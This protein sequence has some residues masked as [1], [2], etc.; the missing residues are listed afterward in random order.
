MSP[1]ARYWLV[2]ASGER[3]AISAAGVMIGRSTRCDVVL[4][5]LRASRRQALVVDGEGGPVVMSLGRAPTSV[6]GAAVESHRQLADGDQLEVPGLTAKVVAGLS[7]IVRMASWLVRT[8]GGAR[9]G[10]ARTPFAIGGSATADLRIPGWPDDAIRLE[11]SEELFALAMVD[12]ELDGN[13]LVGGDS[14]RIERAATIRCGDT[15]IHLT[16]ADGEGPARS[17]PELRLDDEPSAA[18]IEFLPRGGRLTVV[19]GKREI[20]VYL[21]E[22]RC[23]LI[24]MLLRPPPP[25]LAGDYIS[26][27]V[28]LPRLWP[29]RV[30][31]RVDLNTL[32]HRV[33]H[34]LTQAGLDGASLLRRAPGGNATRFVLASGAIVRLL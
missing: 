3:F 28:V 34:D 32:L 12:V 9:F 13:L 19:L 2:L 27:D 8:D 16:P 33:R 14:A 15:A 4:D 7:G 6:N 1:R 10:I 30:M 23:D 22:R 24:A 26:D 20:T 17:S 11:L 18:S 25:L 29:G 5:D 21:A 31:S